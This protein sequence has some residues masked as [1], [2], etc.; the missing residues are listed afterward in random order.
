MPK[1]L[2][3]KLLSQSAELLNV[4]TCLAGHVSVLRSESPSELKPYQRALSG[5]QGRERFIISVDNSEYKTDQHNLIGFGESPHTSSLTVA[6]F[7]SSAGLLE[8]AISGLLT[9]FGLEGLEEKP[10]SSLTPDADRKI[11][12][13]AATADPTKALIINEPFEPILSQWRDQVA[14]LLLDF[15]GS[16]NGIVVIPSLSYRPDSWVDNATVIR[17]QVGQS[18]RRTIGFGAAGSESTNLM[19]QIRDQIRDEGNL[20]SPAQQRRE[21]GHPLS[22]SAAALASTLESQEGAPALNARRVG[23]PFSRQATV[24]KALGAAGLCGLIMWGTPR[25]LPR[26]PDSAGTNSGQASITQPNAAQGGASAVTNSAENAKL[27]VSGEKES[28][29]KQ[30]LPEKMVVAFVLDKYPASIRAS[31]LDT[32]HGVIGEPAASA[33]PAEIPRAGNQP[34]KDESGNLYKLLE[35]ASDS[36]RDND[37]SFPA[38]GADSLDDEDRDIPQLEPEA[39]PD[40]EARREEIRQKFLQAIQAAAQNR[41]DQ[42]E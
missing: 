39:D 7:L 9:S 24:L 25:L 31:I 20:P 5:N 22:L 1:K 28:T 36:G 26:K 18:L 3:I 21:D 33:G 15:A 42:E 37:Q 2:Q 41:D 13:F 40:Q 35:K 17:H 30:A 8:G 38:S 10:C 12:L 11:R 34:Q 29:G 14:D 16:K 32:A 6:A 23:G 4:T 27:L 19:N